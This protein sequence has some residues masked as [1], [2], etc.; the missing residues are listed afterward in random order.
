MIRNAQI[1]QV[2]GPFTANIDLLDDNQAIGILTPEKQ[3]PEIYKIGIQSTPG[4]RVSINGRIIKIGVTGIYELDDIIRIKSLSFPDGAPQNT[5]I[6]FA[7]F[8]DVNY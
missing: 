6:D 3:K 2:S 5:L 8:G 1:G 4:T 7:Y